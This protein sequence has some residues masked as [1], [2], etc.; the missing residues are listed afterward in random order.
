MALFFLL[1]FNFSFRI[2]AKEMTGGVRLVDSVLHIKRKTYFLES[3]NSG[4]P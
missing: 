4:N 3:F 1:Q 2:F